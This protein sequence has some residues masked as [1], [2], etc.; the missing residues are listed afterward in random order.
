MSQRCSERV[1]VL[2][3]RLEGCHDH[4]RLDG[5]QIDP[6]QR[7]PDPGVDYNALVE[8]AIQHID[9]AGSDGGSL[10]SH[11]RGNL[12]V[13]A[14]GPPHTGS[15]VLEFS[16]E[17]PTVRGPPELV[18][19]RRASRRTRELSGGKFLALRVTHGRQPRSVACEPPYESTAQASARARRRGR[20]ASRNGD[21]GYAERRG[22]RNQDSEERTRSDR[23]S[24]LG[25]LARC[26]RARFEDA[27]RDGL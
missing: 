1:G 22:L 10:D 2:E 17:Y 23:D 19:D 5:D 6:Y 25:F 18:R 7:Y 21:Q 24:R 20:R 15:E 13:T 3:V 27:H 14:I 26:H 8:H 16:V 11:D 12:R 4:A 9:Q